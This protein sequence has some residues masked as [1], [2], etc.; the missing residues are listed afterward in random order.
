MNRIFYFGLFSIGIFTQAALAQ[1]AYT[2]RHSIGDANSFSIEL[3][4]DGS[5]VRQITVTNLACGTDF[6]FG[7][8]TFTLAL[9]SN[10]PLS[11][12]RFSAK[13]LPITIS[14]HEHALDIDGALFDADG[15]NSIKE[16]QALGGLSFVSGVN[17]CHFR[18]WATAVAVDSDADGWSDTA[19]RRL[20]SI[21]VEQHSG[22]SERSRNNFHFRSRRLQRLRGQRS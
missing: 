14:D 21:L 3:S 6:P 20:G 16:E 8:H 2:G 17:R 5:A 7:R 15:D 22:A 13:A 11:N 9:N 18:W 10:L 19:E 1:L 12:G 4:A